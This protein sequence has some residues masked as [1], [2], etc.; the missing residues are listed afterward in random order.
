MA[1]LKLLRWP[2]LGALLLS[3]FIAGCAAP[4]RMPSQGGVA[5]PPKETPQQEAAR[6]RDQR[7]QSDATAVVVYSAG[8]LGQVGW[9]RMLVQPVGH[10]AREQWLSVSTNCGTECMRRK[11]TVRKVRTVVQHTLSVTNLEPGKWRMTTLQFGQRKLTLKKPVVFEVKNGYATYLGGFVVQINPKL[12]VYRYSALQ[13]DLSRAL[14]VYP[15]TRGRRMINTVKKLRK[16][17]LMR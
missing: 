9:Y 13:S 17:T 2:S 6:I 14:S 12:G 16:P 15:Q 3:L 10:N 5:I 1:G 4:T 7:K 8:S 11:L